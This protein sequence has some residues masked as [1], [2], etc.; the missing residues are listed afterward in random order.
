MIFNLIVKPRL[1]LFLEPKPVLNNEVKSFVLKAT[2]GIFYR[3]RVIFLISIYLIY[4][5]M[6][7]STERSV[8][9]V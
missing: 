6:L 9:R 1:N 4:V 2:M 5:L 7:F 8:W 3:V